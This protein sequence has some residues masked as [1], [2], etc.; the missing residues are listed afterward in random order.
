M[1]EVIKNAARLRD[2]LLD[3]AKELRLRRDGNIELWELDA[4][5]C[6]DAAAML[7]KLGTEVTRLRL[8]IGHHKYGMMSCADLFQ[9]PDT[10][11]DDG[12][13]A[14]RKRD[15]SDE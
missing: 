11:N 15:K 2:H 6:D 9:I 4:K 13:E 12:G 14:R 7:R 5:A 8:A 3:V 1:N 10:W